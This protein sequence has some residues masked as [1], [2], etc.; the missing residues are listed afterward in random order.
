VLTGRCSRRVVVPSR[1]PLAE[2]E[3]VRLGAGLQERDLKRP[4]ADR[5]VLAYE[6]VQATFPEQ[7]G[8][9]LVDVDAV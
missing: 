3:R 2:R 6:L 7:A 1:E 8:P 9:V 5:A 4:V